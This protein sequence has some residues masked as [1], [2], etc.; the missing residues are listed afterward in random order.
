[1]AQKG[2]TPLFFVYMALSLYYFRAGHACEGVIHDL[3]WRPFFSVDEVDHVTQL[4]KI[5]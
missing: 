4:D 3:E 5:K 1:M 2:G